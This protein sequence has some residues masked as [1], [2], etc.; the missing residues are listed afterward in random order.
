VAREL[1]R[2]VVALVQEID[3]GE[4]QPTPDWLL[5]PGPAECGRRWP[6]VQS[7][8][9]ELADSA[10]PDVMPAKERRQV[11][12]VLKKPGQPARIIE[13][14]EKQHFNLYRAKTLLMYPR[15]VRLAFPK[16]VWVEQSLHK[17]KLEAGGF[18]RPCPP[19]FPGS[20]GRHRQR[21]Y[22]D[23]LA[24]VVPLAH[25]WLPT[26]RIADFEVRDWVYGPDAKRRMKALLRN[27]LP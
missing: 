25:G 12:A 17:R 21:A 7:M 2:A 18:A 10:L 4:E 26:L 19:L 1:E 15:G 8:Y 13:V 24:D 14:D 22:R 23:A 16:R 9:R 20:G 27:R 3:G 5:R 6:F 11:D